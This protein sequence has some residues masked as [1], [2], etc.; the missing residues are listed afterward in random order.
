[1][2]NQALELGRVRAKIAE[3]QARLDE[4]EQSARSAL[5]A[6]QD[7]KF[8]LSIALVTLAHLEGD[9]PRPLGAAPEGDKVPVIEV[10]Q[11]KPAELSEWDKSFD[12]LVNG[13]DHVFLTGPGGAGKSTMLQK[14]IAQAHGAVVAAP[15]GRAALNVGGTTIH[16]LFRFGAHAITSDDIYRLSD[17][18]RA[19][20]RAMNTLVLDEGSMIRG[21]LMDGIDLFL[22][23]NGKTDKKPFGGVRI[24]IV[25]DLYQLPPVAKEGNE[26]KWLMDRYGVEEPYMIH[27]EV[28]R[29]T[30]LNLVN[31]THIF[32]QDDP[33]LTDALNAV[34]V[35]QATPDHLAM[36]N[37][38]VR[39]HN[40]VP[41]QD[42]LWVTMTTTRNLADQA[43]ARM[44]SELAGTSTYYD[45]VVEGDFNL[46]DT[47]AD[48]RL[49]LKVGAAVMFVRNDPEGAWVNGTMGKVTSLDPLEVEVKGRELEVAKVEWSEY[50]YAYDQKLRKLTKTVKGKFTQYPLKLAA[51]MTVHK[52]QGATLD[53]AIVDLGGGSFAAG[54][55]YTA[56]SRVRALSGLALRRPLIAKD[57][58]VNEEVKKFMAG[59]SI[60]RPVPLQPSL[61]P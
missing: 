7:G 3:A 40:W 6:A 10:V 16:R 45:A 35:G 43:N 5:K 8:A 9:A 28:W 48:T 30:P 13:T 4:A 59:Q 51:A 33:T 36:F 15:S 29:D 47:P 17:D 24:V 55:T 20:Y 58:I 12:R 42:E 25:G 39:G 11:G 57:I 18:R 61:I 60:T 23:K 50:V 53:R 26:R 49:E 31:L 46:N 44:L 2:N 34:R 54:Q 14:F 37:G 32:R 41:P 56:L 27:A 1:M 52:A 19:M 21:D 22:R 38:Q